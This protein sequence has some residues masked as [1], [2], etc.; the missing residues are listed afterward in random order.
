MQVVA[1]PG[2]LQYSCQRSKAVSISV[3]LQHSHPLPSI[4]ALLTAQG[5][6]LAKPASCQACRTAPSPTRASL[7]P[8]QGRKPHTGHVPLTLCTYLCCGPLPA[9]QSVGGSRTKQSVATWSARK[10]TSTSPRSLA[11]RRNRASLRA[12]EGSGQKL[13]ARV[14]ILLGPTSSD[15][16]L[17]V[18]SALR[19]WEN[20]CLFLLDTHL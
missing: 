9:L 5:I 20:P 6:T 17:P 11:L 1:Q 18:C 12:Q 14:G 3:T 10:A 7:L 4:P 15:P 16:K 8:T 13:L 19:W 2:S